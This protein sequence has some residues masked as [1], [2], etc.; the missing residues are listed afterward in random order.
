MLVVDKRV[1]E[2]CVIV[3][4]P[5][6]A[7]ILSSFI[8]V[9]EEI[10]KRGFLIY[11]GER[12]GEKIV[13]STHG[14]GGPSVS[15]ILNE[16]IKNGAK[17][18]LRYGTAGALNEKVKVGSYF[19]PIGVS[20]HESSSLYQMLRQDIIPALSPDLELTYRLYSFLKSQ[21]IEVS[22]GTLFQS[23]DFYSE[24]HLT[25]DDAVDMESGTI[26]LLGKVY[27]VRT[28]SLLIIA[29]YKGENW[30]NYEEIYRRDAGKVIDFM[31]SFNYS[32]LP[33]R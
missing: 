24:S 1:P 3:E 9:N 26:F 23:D 30:I 14:V 5:E 7:E 10:R 28:A 32:E 18:V 19:I 6:V 27:G 29:N 21:G 8:T 2:R 31:I 11:I 20:H 13:I 16:L 12:K 25:F 17:L 22:Y 15:L 4:E 33:T